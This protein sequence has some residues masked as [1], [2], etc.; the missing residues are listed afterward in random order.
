MTT[1]MSFVN[2]SKHLFIFNFSPIWGIC[3]NFLAINIFFKW[4]YFSVVT[5]VRAL[6]PPKLAPSNPMPAVSTG[7]YMSVIIFIMAGF[8]SVAFFTLI[9]LMC[10]KRR[11]RWKRRKRCVNI[12]HLIEI[13]RFSYT[14]GPQPQTC[15]INNAPETMKKM[16]VFG[17]RHEFQ[18][19]P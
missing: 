16:H 9:L 18:E 5:S 8:A 2:R 15:S 3:H 14:D 4:F 12:S 1:N 13:V 11:K 10:L 17:T 6:P 19:N 7:Y